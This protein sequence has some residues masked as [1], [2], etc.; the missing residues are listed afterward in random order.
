[1][2]F[3]WSP[4]GEAC[5]VWCQ[6]LHDDTG[7]SYYGQSVLYI[8]HVANATFVQV[9]KAEGPIHDVSWSP[10]SDCFAMLSGFMPASAVLMDKLCQIKYDFNQLYANTLRWSPLCGR[11]LLGGFGNLSGNIQIWDMIEF[12]KV[13]ECRA[14]SAI[15]CQWA[16][17][18]CKFFTAIVNPRLRVDNHYRVYKFD[19]EYYTNFSLKHTELYEVIWQPGLHHDRPVQPKTT[20]TTSE[21]ETKA[22]KSS[23]VWNEQEPLKPIRKE[24][25]ELQ[26]KQPIA[27]KNF[28]KF[29]KPLAQTPIVPPNTRAQQNPSYLPAGLPS[30]LSIGRSEP[31]I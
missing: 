31:L 10:S 19:G 4:D 2:S 18:G 22:R 27:K 13:G 9:P 26:S 21:D 24:S 11:L 16:A 20:I 28:N 23:K 6:T 29:A 17:D 25:E 5:L 7:K 3:L 14:L 30:N 15:T 8:Y 1:M 12:K